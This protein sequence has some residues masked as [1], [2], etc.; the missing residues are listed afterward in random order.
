MSDLPAIELN[1]DLAVAVVI[2][3]FELADVACRFS[4]SVKCRERIKRAS[5]SISERFR[6]RVRSSLRCAQSSE[7]LKGVGRG[8]FETIA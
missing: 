5:F 6:R 7:H 4:M 2:D 8:S 3:L 1:D